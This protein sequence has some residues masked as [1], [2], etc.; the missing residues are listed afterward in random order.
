MALRPSLCLLALALDLGG[1]TTPNPSFLDGYAEGTTTADTTADATTSGPAATATGG[2][3]PT[4]TGGATGGVT[5]TTDGGETTENASGSST[6]GIDPPPNCGDGV[7]DGDEE[8]D[9]APVMD[10][11]CTPVCT[12]NTCG[13][14]YPLG[15]EECDEG[16]NNADSGECTLAC[17]INVC[18]DGKKGPDEACDD[19]NALD[20]DACLSSC[21]K[22]SCGDGIK[23]PVIG[24]VCDGGPDN[25][26]VPGGCA[27]NCKQLIPLDPLAVKVTAFVTD[28]AFADGD[29]V[30]ELDSACVSS[31]G[32]V[33]KALFA[34]GDRVASTSANTGEGQADWVL[35]PHRA[36]TNANGELLGITGKEALLGVHLGEPVP[37]LHPISQSFAGVWTG[38]GEGWLTSESDCGEWN[39]NQGET[40]GAIGLPNKL[41]TEFYAGGESSCSQERAIYCAEQP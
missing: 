27:E 5:S 36:Y 4:G 2:P 32:E 20:D 26:L 23:Q 1:C 11:P 38:L 31:F 19:G 25:G 41:G 13:D 10:V 30:A 34:F 16:D 39:D 9:G 14:G 8:C 37:L 40:V 33:Y 15:A 29:P 35:V 3:L 21:E 7:L 18:G 17:A 28:G 6:T 22:A 24:E 12:L